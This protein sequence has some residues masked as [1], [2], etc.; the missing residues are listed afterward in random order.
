MKSLQDLKSQFPNIEWPKEKVAEAFWSYQMNGT[1]EQVWPF[2]A[3]TSR[4]NRALGLVQK[5]CKQSNDQLVM[6][7]SLFGFAQQWVESPWC[8]NY[9]QYIIIN[10]K[11][12]CGA[13]RRSIKIY[14]LEP[15]NSGKV[16]VHLY[17]G[18]EAKNFFLKL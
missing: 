15:L 17:L 7:D 12:L 6:Q 3:D 1:I 4:F 8:W 2:L 14:W 13:A 9:G 5:V 18:W 16:V 11:Y 10:K